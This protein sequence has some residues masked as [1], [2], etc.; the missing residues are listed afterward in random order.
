ML[1]T[2]SCLFLVVIA[3]CGDDGGLDAGLDVG[4]DAPMDSGSDV[5]PDVGTDA[6]VDSGRDASDSG[7]ALPGFGAIAGP[8]AMI[9]GELT[10]GT[11]SYFSNRLDFG[12]DAFDDPDDVSRLT[13]GG[14]EIL[15]EG[16]AGGS[17]GLSEA[18][19]YEVLARCEGATL[20]KSETEIVYEPMGTLTDM[21]VEIDGTKIGVS[22]TR[23]FV[24]PT[25][26]PYTVA[27]ASDQLMDKLADILVSS[28]NVVAEDAWAKQIL[29]FMAYGEMHA[30]SLMTAWAALDPSV[31]ADTIVYVVITDGMDEPLY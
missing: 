7:A 15:A 14:Q 2:A 17:S 8:C 28:A 5:G 30:D 13:S 4:A 25:S 29:V 10:T 11:P 6:P 20:L 3:A 23:A 24:F 18:F 9:T 21:L 22:V 26:D 19:A 1:R 16:T 12:D 31:T 27:I